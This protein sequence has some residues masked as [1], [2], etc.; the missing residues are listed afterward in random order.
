MLEL[1]RKEIK[2][3]EVFSKL[4]KELVSKH[5]IAKHTEETLLKNWHVKDFCEIAVHF[6][7]VHGKRALFISYEI[8]TWYK[9]PNG[10]RARVD[11]ITIYDDF[12][13]YE[14]TRQR[15]LHGTK[16]ADIPNIN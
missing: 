15:A 7:I 1:S 11:S 2:A 10:V 3:D 8:S 5:E 4:L 6:T 14:S 16:R 12:M 13:E 9:E